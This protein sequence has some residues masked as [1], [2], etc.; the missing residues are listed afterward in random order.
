[1]EQV[2]KNQNVA[3]GKKT[4]MPDRGDHKKDISPGHKT[5]KSESDLASKNSANRD[6]GRRNDKNERNDHERTSR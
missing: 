4:E 3:P 5:T 6:D 1:M 2:K